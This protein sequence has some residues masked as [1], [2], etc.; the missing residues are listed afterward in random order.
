MRLSGPFRLLLRVRAPQ[1]AH[2]WTWVKSGVGFVSG[3]SLIEIPSAPLMMRGRHAVARWIPLLNVYF[4]I[5]SLQIFAKG[6]LDLFPDNADELDAVSHLFSYWNSVCAEVLCLTQSK[7]RNAAG[8]LQPPVLRRLGATR[9]CHVFA[10]LMKV[11]GLGW[12]C[13]DVQF[14]DMFG[15]D[16]EDLIDVLQC[17]FDQ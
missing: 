2:R 7:G 8:V 16:M 1:L 6:T 17:P 12:R 9:R 10:H 13:G 15:S 14:F 4:H 5:D 3:T 11:V